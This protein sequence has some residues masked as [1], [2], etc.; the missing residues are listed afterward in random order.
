MNG[1][2]ESAPS[3]TVSALPL[4]RPWA[5]RSLTAKVGD[6]YVRLVWNPPENNG[7]YPV[8]EYRVYRWTEGGEAVLLGTTTEVAYNDTSVT[9]GVTYYYY[10]TAVNS[11]GESDPSNEVNATPLGTPS[12]PQNLTATAGDGEVV[13]KWEAPADNG[14]TPVIR[15]NIY[16]GTSPDNMVLISNVSA[17]NT[18]FTDTGV[19]NGN[20][21]YYYVRAVNAVGEGEASETV[22]VTPRGSAFYDPTSPLFPVFILLLLAGAVLAVLIVYYIRRQREREKP[23]ESGVREWRADEGEETMEMAAVEE[24]MA[25]KTD[26]SIAEEE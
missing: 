7:G 16:R 18:T 24:E 12:S 9:N 21:Y 20:T 2:G 8:T 13:L 6:G 23:V 14:G 19:E 10:V 3:D 25:D 5:P 22:S 4:G 17:D 11:H 15:Y 26:E 1:V